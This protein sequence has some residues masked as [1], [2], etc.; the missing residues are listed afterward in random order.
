MVVVVVVVVVAA[1]CCYVF[2]F[3]R[4]CFVD[5]WCCTG[6]LDGLG[7]HCSAAMLKLLVRCTVDALQQLAC[8]DANRCS[9]P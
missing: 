4:R 7:D 6:A 1:C 3:C 2:D 8:L 5:A 9:R